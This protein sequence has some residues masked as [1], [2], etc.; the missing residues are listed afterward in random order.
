MYHIHMQKY[1]H[2]DVNR[3]KSFKEGTGKK[4]WESIANK[5]LLQSGLMEGTKAR[6]RVRDGKLII[7]VGKKIKYLNE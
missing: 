4:Y 6:V 5:L 1:K 7:R 3:D 2:I